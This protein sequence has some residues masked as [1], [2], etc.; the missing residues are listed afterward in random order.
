M[1]TVKE[2]YEYI[3][4]FAPEEMALDTDNVGFLVGIGETEV[5]KILVCLDITSDVIAEAIETGVQLIVAHH[6]LFFE[7]KNV[8]DT[9]ITGSKIVR[10]LS[11]GISAICMHT[12][13]DA[14][15]GGV[16][17]ALAV[18][19]GIID[20][21]RIAEPLPGHK[22]LAT[23]EVFSLGRVGNLNKP[24][25]MPDY[26]ARLKNAL[27]VNGLRYHDAERGVYRVAI[28]SG[29]GS[30]EWENALKS[31]CDTFVTADIKYHL[32]LEAKERGINLIDAGHFSTENL[33]S[34][35]LVSKLKTAFPTVK[36]VE[37]K[38][39]DQTVA[40]F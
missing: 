8:T 33:V 13:L 20:D 37:S 24:C 12:N 6:P 19:V 10:L 2:I 40:F 3:K 38:T 27:G 39:Q 30:A 34:D 16:N 35:V 7:L 32:F 21:S 9:D 31:G 23:G 15:G 14:A 22:S 28:S 29:A 5:T 4:T 17:D 26:L 11:N 18:A 1:P 25:S 36:S